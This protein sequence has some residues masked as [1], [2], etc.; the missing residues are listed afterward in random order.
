MALAALVMSIAMFAAFAAPAMADDHPVPACGKKL[1][2]NN[3]HC[4]APTV[5]REITLVTSPAPCTVLVEGTNLSNYDQIL[6]EFDSLIFNENGFLSYLPVYQPGSTLNVASTSV[7]N[8][9]DGSV[10]ISSSAICGKNLIVTTALFE[11][12]TVGTAY[13]ETVTIQA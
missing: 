3:K 1:L 5:V 11:G 7:T 13:Y 9:V 12:S 2:E 8:N 4:A 6:L 10:T